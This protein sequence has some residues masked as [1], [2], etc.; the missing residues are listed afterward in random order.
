MLLPPQGLCRRGAQAGGDH[1]RDLN[2]RHVLCRRSG[3]K[4]G[5]RRAPRPWQESQAA[6][7][8]SMNGATEVETQGAGTPAGAT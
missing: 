6:G 2:R 5:G 8:A 4:P 3:G 7:S 1:A